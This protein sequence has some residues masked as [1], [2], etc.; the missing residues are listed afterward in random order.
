MV[1]KL[2]RVIRLVKNRQNPY[3]NEF[4]DD[5][6]KAIR[7]AQETGGIVIAGDY[8]ERAFAEAMLGLWEDCDDCPVCEI[9][10]KGVK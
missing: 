5:E 7:R 2:Y 6:S 9:I 4:F 8:S 10:L 3:Q 1:R